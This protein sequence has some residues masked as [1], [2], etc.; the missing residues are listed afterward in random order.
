MTY[1][2]SYTGRRWRGISMKSARKRLR[3]H[4]IVGG[5]AERLNSTQLTVEHR[6]SLKARAL[7]LLRCL[8]P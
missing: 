2:P 1:T 7:H 4:A 3:R 8:I 5:I 6:K